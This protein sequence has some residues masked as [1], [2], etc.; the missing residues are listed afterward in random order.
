MAKWWDI[1]RSFAG[2]PF[3]I[4]HTWVL[5]SGY[6]VEKEQERT[7]A[8]LKAVCEELLKAK[9]LQPSPDGSIT[10]CSEFVLRCALATD[11]NSFKLG[12]VA[13]V[14]IDIMSDEEN[15]WSMNTPEAAVLH[16]SRGGLAIAAAKGTP[17]GHVCVVAPYSME[18]SMSLGRVVPV[19]YNCGKT[20]GLMRVTQ[21]FPVAGGMP[22]FY[23]WEN[24]NT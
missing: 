1:W 8:E 5:G 20:V 19:V 11:C 9:D 7:V 15:G 16:A 14:Q 4:S 22:N 13:N 24:P 2:R 12:D 23:L 10:H 21:A 3:S 17:H 18:M 6:S